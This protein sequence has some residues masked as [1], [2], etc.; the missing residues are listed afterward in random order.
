MKLK[1]FRGELTDI[2]AKK[3]PLVTNCNEP[4]LYFQ[5]VSY[6]EVNLYNVFGCFDPENRILC[7]HNVTSNMN[8]DINK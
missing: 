5:R 7:H 1:H 6:V 8:Y 2:S 3:E 4:F